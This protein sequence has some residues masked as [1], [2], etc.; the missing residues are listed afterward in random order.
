[1]KTDYSAMAIANYF[2]KS[3]EEKGIPPLKMQKLV[4]IAHGWH[5]ALYKEPLVAD[6][7]AEA[8]EYGPVFPSLHHEFKY[9]GR[10]PIIEFATDICFDEDGNL[11]TETPEILEEDTRTNGSTTKIM[12]EVN[13]VKESSTKM[14]TAP[15]VAGGK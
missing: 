9:R 3:Y 1:M 6:E 7:Y 14:C 13:W 11:T 5:L 2:L 4:Y 10:L 12:H 15:N 8:W